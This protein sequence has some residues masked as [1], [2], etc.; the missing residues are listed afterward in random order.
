MSHILACNTTREFNRI[1]M[2]TFICHIFFLH[3][4]ETP[5]AEREFTLQ[6]TPPQIEW[7]L[8]RNKEQFDILTVRIKTVMAL[9]LSIGWFTS[10]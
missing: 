10:A 5:N 3:Q 1:D 7:H 8:V 9:S 2:H 4:T 6:K